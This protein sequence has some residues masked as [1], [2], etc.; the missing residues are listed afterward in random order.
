M[1]LASYSVTV[2]KKSG[3]WVDATYLHES[4]K[5]IPTFYPLPESEC[6]K[7][8]DTEKVKIPGFGNEDITIPGEK[9][10]SILASE[11][12]NSLKVKLSKVS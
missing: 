1:Y 8:W 2:L 10:D 5:L 4:S 7:L 12:T 11:A 6:E 9:V 3:W